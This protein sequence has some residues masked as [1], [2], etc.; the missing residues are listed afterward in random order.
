ML[1]S[2]TLRERT[3]EPLG[4]GGDA[5]CLSRPESWAEEANLFGEGSGPGNGAPW[6]LTMQR[7]L[8]VA[9]STVLPL[10]KGRC[11]L[12]ALS[13]KVHA[14]PWTRLLGGEEKGVEGSLLKGPRWG[15]GGLLQQ[16]LGSHS[17]LAS[18]DLWGHYSFIHLLIQEILGWPKLGLGFPVV[19]VC[20]CVISRLFPTPWSVAH[21]APLSA[22]FSRQDYWSG[23][24][25]F[26]PGDLPDS[27]V[28]SMVPTLVGGFLTTEPPGKPTSEDLIGFIQQLM[29]RVASHE[30]IRKM[31]WGA[32]PNG[33]FL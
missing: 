7:S 6:R 16:L 4:L 32:V 24:L 3:W 13:T 10:R 22:G 18:G 8:V 26:S 21:Q 15:G 29:S 28:K 23:L 2:C 12:T 1:P 11:G 9:S 30:A 17:S 5:S 27:G 14:W 33:R 20:A 31:L 19:Y 25:F